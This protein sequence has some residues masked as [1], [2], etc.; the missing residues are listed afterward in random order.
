MSLFPELIFPETKLD[1]MP[2]LVP[3]IEMIYK[4]VAHMASNDR[5]L[6]AEGRCGSPKSIK[7]FTGECNVE[8]LYD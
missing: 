6:I 7:V 4:I 1:N 8:D 2:F 5:V 3:Q